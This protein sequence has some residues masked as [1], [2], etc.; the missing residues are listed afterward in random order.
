MKMRA[1]TTHLLRIE[2]VSEKVC[3]VAH[4]QTF[5][6]NVL[7]FLWINAQ[8]SLSYLDPDAQTNK[9][10]TRRVKLVFVNGET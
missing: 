10:L 5:I 7:K 4:M 9:I 1:G 8:R 6:M 3:S 2:N